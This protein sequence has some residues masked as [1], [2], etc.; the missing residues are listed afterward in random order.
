[1]YHDAAG[2]AAAR[3]LLTGIAER[4]TAELAT[5]QSLSLIE[6]SVPEHPA[7][8]FIYAWVSLWSTADPRQVNAGAGRVM[9]IEAVAR[10]CGVEVREIERT[11]VLV[12]A[13]HTPR[14]CAFPGFRQLAL[15]VR[16]RRGLEAA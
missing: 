2:I 4:L 3:P 5:G 1:V 10:A 11:E 6:S 7:E 13:T 16:S 9:G 12:S 8:P 14:H 15:G